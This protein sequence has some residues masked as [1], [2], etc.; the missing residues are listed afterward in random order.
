MQIKT[1]TNGVVYEMEHT[2]LEVGEVTISVTYSGGEFG[3]W[4]FEYSTVDY[5]R[6]MRLDP[7]QIRKLN[8][9]LE[10]GLEEEVV[11]RLI[12]FYETS[13]VLF[14]PN[15]YTYLIDSFNS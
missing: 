15:E 10:C 12:A 7:E 4:E 6:N 14:S 5:E 3:E 13:D 11:L 9:E 1:V 8:K 2:F